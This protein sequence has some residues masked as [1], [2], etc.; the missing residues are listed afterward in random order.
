MTK[1]GV[2]LLSI[3]QEKG[4]DPMHGAVLLVA[5]VGPSSGAGTVASGV[6]T[7]VPK[8][9]WGGTHI[10]GHSSSNVAM[11]PPDLPPD[12]RR[13]VCQNV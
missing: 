4:D 8:W 11:L 9:R 2:K 6:P 12:V 10:A 7:F 5:H 1:N 3:T 13:Y